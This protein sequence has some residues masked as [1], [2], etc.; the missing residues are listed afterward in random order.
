MMTFSKT[1]LFTALCAVVFAA[2]AISTADAALSRKP[3]D[4]FF[5]ATATDP[6]GLDPALVDDAESGNVVC[7]VYE[8]LLKFKPDSTEVEPSLAESYTVSEDGLV[9]TFKLRQGVKFHDGT[10]FNAEAVKFNIDRQMPEVATPKMSYASLVYGDVDHTDVIDEYTVQISLK[11]PSTPFLHNLAMVYAAPIVSPA[12]L[13]A[14]NNNVNMAPC[15]TGPYKFVAWDKGQQ[16]I[17]TRNEEY[18]GEPGKTA[19]LIFRVMP[20]ASARVVALNNGEVDAITGVDVNTVKEI[21]DGGSKLFTAEGMNV[22]YMFFNCRDTGTT[23]KLDKDVRRAIAMAVNK[24]ELVETLYKGYATPATTILPSFVPGYSA[25]VK[26][27]TYNPEEAKKIFESKGIDS[28]T[29]MTYSGARAYNTVGGQVLAEAVQAYLD[30]VGVKADVLVYDWATFKA[31]L[32]TDTW[33]VGFIGWTGDNGDPDNFLNLFASDDPIANQ[34]LWVNQEY[35]DLI[36]KAAATPEGP[37]RAALYEQA[38]Q[39]L[40]DEAGVI[41]LSHAKAMGGYRPN[42]EGFTIH[43]VGNTFLMNVVKH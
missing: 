39:L 13:K 3:Q 32:L 22:S 34:G 35:R 15:G 18:W 43:S 12:A 10:P 7:N 1:K 2:S 29:I 37:E 6:L 38:E 5:L 24:D 8:S 9:Y 16:V 20:E 11:K 30:K 40:A 33:D 27:V 42:V 17:V 31:K 25:N 26:P 41:P 19:N 28:L 14:N 23:I 21:T 36:S 4:N